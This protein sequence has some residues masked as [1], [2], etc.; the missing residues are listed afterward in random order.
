MS[1][2]D[3]DQVPAI[4]QWDSSSR[5]PSPDP[6]NAAFNCGPTCV[7]FLADFYRDAAFGINAT[8]LLG[9]VENYT[10][11]SIQNQELMLEKRGVPCSFSQPSLATLRYLTGTQRHPVMVGLLM[12]RVAAVIRG[13][14]FTGWH[15]VVL[16]KT[17]YADVPGF[18]VLDPNF[19]KITGRVDPT[20][21]HRFYPETVIAYAMQ[22][23]YA[24]IP[25]AAKAVAVAIPDTS[26]PAPS[27]EQLDVNL[28]DVTIPSDAGRLFAVK[29]GVTLYNDARMTSVRTRLAAAA[30][31]KLIGFHRNGSVLASNPGNPNGHPFIVPPKH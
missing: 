24:L 15:A 20:N 29:A 6:G 18:D 25:N 8:R 23:G 31:F 21:G 30:N 27:T 3:I 1:Y 22:G 11:T 14:D 12:S 19:S 16:R 9:K 2:T 7:T 17:R 5:L 26:T 4:F 10:P 13:H 28:L